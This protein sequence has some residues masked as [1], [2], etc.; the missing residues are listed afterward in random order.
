MKP[1]AGLLLE[2]LRIG[3]QIEAR[4]DDL[5]RAERRRS[6]DLLA[7]MQAFEID[8]GKVQRR[9]LARCGDL[10]RLAMNVNRAST[11]PV[12]AGQDFHFLVDMNLSRLRRAGD[13][14]SEPFH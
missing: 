10:S 14:R 1:D 8:V 7:S 2:R 6:H 4:R 11:A 9:A 3:K 12:T 13:D 5:R